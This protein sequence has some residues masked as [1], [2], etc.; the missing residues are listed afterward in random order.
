MIQLQNPSYVT[1]NE[2]NPVLHKHSKLDFQ[3]AN[4]NEELTFTMSKPEELSY[5]DRTTLRF[6]KEDLTQAGY[7]VN[8]SLEKLEVK[9]PASLN[10]ASRM[11]ALL[12]SNDIKV[13]SEQN[14][15]KSY[16][17][18]KHKPNL[19]Y[20]GFFRNH[21]LF[22]KLQKGLKSVHKAIT[23]KKFPAIKVIADVALWQSGSLKGGID[24]KHDLKH[25]IVDSIKHPEELETAV[26]AAF[27]QIKTNFQ[28]DPAFTLGDAKKQQ[29]VTLDLDKPTGKLSIQFD[30][31][32]MDHSR[33]LN[34]TLRK[35]SIT[36]PQAKVVNNKVFINANKDVLKQVSTLLNKSNMKI[37]HI[38]NAALRNELTK[39][40]NSQKVKQSLRL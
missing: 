3:V 8:E 35:L 12:S 7:Q 30:S 19:L 28:Q 2:Y 29:S 17:S 13:N 1:Q 37:T 5:M 16:F 21:E 23:N 34:R 33:E 11:K 24:V 18:N 15:L 39:K 6:L 9:A 26:K 32:G 20:S 40:S 38:P 14:L 25:F 10:N 31:R 36:V 4:N 22:D 27:E